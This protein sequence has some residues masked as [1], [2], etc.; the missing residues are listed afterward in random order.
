MP[1]KVNLT[2]TVAYDLLIIGGHVVDPA[3]NV[4]EISDI[5]MRGGVI[6]AVGPDLPREGTKN[7]FDA[8]GM[9][10]TPGLIDTYVHV[11]DGIAPFG[12]DAAEHCLSRGSTTV[13][14]AGDAGCNSLAGLKTHVARRA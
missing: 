10:L 11:F 2:T 9:L 1:S 8:S 4:D 5:A 3:N 14:D 12:L 13:L 7:V 6:A